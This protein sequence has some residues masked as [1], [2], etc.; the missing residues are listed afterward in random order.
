MV[1]HMRDITQTWQKEENIFRL[2]L[3]PARGTEEG[4]WFF[5]CFLFCCCLFKL[6]RKMKTCTTVSR[7]GP[8][9]ATREIELMMK[10]KVKKR[11]F[12]FWRLTKQ[13]LRELSFDFCNVI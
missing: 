12:F 2:F 11:K 13:A 3:F 5:F 8:I 1:R 10:T 7:N 9:N 6:Q 4:N